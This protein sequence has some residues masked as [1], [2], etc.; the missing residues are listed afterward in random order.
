MI[1]L[2]EHSY[3][4]LARQGSLSQFHLVIVPTSH[5]PSSTAADEAVLEEFHLWKRALTATFAEHGAEP[6]F[7]ETVVSLKRGRHVQLECIPLP[8]NLA[9]QAPAYF[10]KAIL[11]SESEWAQHKKL[12]DASGVK[13]LRR[14]IPREFP[15]FHVQVGLRVGFAHVIED[16]KDFPHFFGREILGGM[17][18]LPPDRVRRPVPLAIDALSEARAK[19]LP[20]FQPHDWTLLLDEVGD[21]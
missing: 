11:E 15:Y 16:E 5:V 1:A 13:D 14:I 21:S 17:L 3:L 12:L 20:M 19:F 2:G 18:D 9:A 7:L 10:K 6:V 4:A 8:N